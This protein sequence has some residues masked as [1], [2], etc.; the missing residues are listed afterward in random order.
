[1]ELLNSSQWIANP[2][3]TFKDYRFFWV[4]MSGEWEQ[5]VPEN[6]VVQFLFLMSLFLLFRCGSLEAACSFCSYE[7]TL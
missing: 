7:Y 6:I 1:M 3:L 4:L 2:L 5:K